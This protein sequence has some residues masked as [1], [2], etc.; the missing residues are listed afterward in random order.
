MKM[1]D[2]P[3][4]LPSRAGQ[5]WL[6]DGIRI[7][8]R[9]PLVWVLSLMTYWAGLVM[10]GILPVVGLFLPLLFTPGLGFGFIVLAEAVDRQDPATPATP[11]LLLAGFR[12]GHARSM[13]QL[14]LAYLAG[15]TLVLVLAWLVDGDQITS[16]MRGGTPSQEEVEVM[17]K[18]LPMGLLVAMLAYIPLMMALW[19]APQLVVWRGFTVGKALF[20]SFF[21]VWRNKAAFLRYSLAWLVLIFLVSGL[22]S[23]IMD[24]FNIGAQS[25]LVTLLPVSML[26][27]AI[28]Q[29]SFYAST[30]DV[31]REDEPLAATA[32]PPAPEE[33]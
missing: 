7:F 25:L 30:R 26:L 11:T 29:A 18:S 3:R 1:Q 23:L 14:G 33:G 8:H 31:F 16:M 28:A 22:S 32:P 6:I 13:L 2:Q 19:F 24:L 17:R 12:N 21:A 20:F 4:Q 9:Q 27:L 10:V 5:T 15:L